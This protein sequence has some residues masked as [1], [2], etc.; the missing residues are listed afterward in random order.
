M[1]AS[2]TTPSKWPHS[3]RGQNA[4]IYVQLLEAVDDVQG[5]ERVGNDQGFIHELLDIRRAAAASER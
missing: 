5:V 2:V 1:S 4:K 3:S